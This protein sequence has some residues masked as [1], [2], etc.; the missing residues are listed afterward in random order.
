MEIKDPW[1]R[2]IS[3]ATPQTINPFTMRSPNISDFF[4][5]NSGLTDLQINNNQQLNENSSNGLMKTNA[6]SMGGVKKKMQLL[7]A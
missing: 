4:E 6:N 5:P 2:N 3:L 7:Q 1:D